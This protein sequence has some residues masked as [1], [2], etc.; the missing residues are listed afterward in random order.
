MPVAFIRRERKRVKILYGNVR[1]SVASR[2]LNPEG[3]FEILVH[4][5]ILSSIEMVRMPD[6]PRI[7]HPVFANVSIW[8][9]TRR[10]PRK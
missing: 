10:G 8:F 5:Q 3:V 2:N 4:L 7:Y 6:L 9:N 1:Y